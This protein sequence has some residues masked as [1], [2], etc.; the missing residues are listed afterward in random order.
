MWIALLL[1]LAHE[2]QLAASRE[3][4][5]Q[6]SASEAQRLQAPGKWDQARDVYEA[7]LRAHP[8]DQAALDGMSVS[9]EHL[10]LE[11]RAAGRMD[12][13]LT[14]LL[15]ANKV[16]P[17]DKRVLLDLGILEDEMG[18]HLDAEQT[19]MRLS[20]LKPDDPTALYALSR[21]HLNLGNL[22]AAEREMQQ[23]L[24]LRP[25]DASAHFGLGRIYLQAL[26]FDQAEEEFRRSVA[27][28]PQQTEAYYQLGQVALQQNKYE[29]AIAEFQ[30]TLAR[31]AKHGGALA[32]IG[33]A[34][35][36]LRK[37]AEAKEWLT[38]AIDAAPQY[39]PGHYYLGLTLARLG[40]APGS[41]QELELATTLATKESKQSAGRL[42][43]NT[44]TSPP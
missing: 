16:E 20:S 19:L 12:D 27:L 21:V 37:Y 26:Q 8:G 5:P 4:P 44:P 40:D 43:L 3:L 1:L 11:Q 14:T 29:P 23:Y 22:A 25:T 33:M 10:A 34:Y 38:R 31:D 13:A 7:A 24:K 41:R 6:A 28:Q 36:K 9:S 15:R 17:D 42:R 35:F 32:G 2:S 30:I 18:L 39:Q